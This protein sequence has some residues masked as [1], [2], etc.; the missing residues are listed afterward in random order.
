ML[1]HVWVLRTDPSNVLSEA[2]VPVSDTF[3]Q[4]IGAKHVNNVFLYL[5]LALDFWEKA[6]E[7]LFQV[8]T[9]SMCLLPDIAWTWFQGSDPLWQ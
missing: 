5:M 1:K 7:E 4:W 3:M 8:Q 9:R 2:N 6:Q